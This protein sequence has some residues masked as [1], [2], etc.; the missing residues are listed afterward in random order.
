[1]HWSRL[2]PSR[3]LIDVQ[4]TIRHAVWHGDGPPKGCTPA[5]IRNNIVL[6]DAVAPLIG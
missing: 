5:V 6:L 4:E 1:M 3:N 2:F